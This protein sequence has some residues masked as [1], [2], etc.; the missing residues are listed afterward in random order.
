MFIATVIC[1]ALL[2]LAFLGSGAMK[3]L[4]KPEI[5]EGLGRLGV[6]PP[7][8]RIIG[9]LELAGAA[10]LLVGFAVP[11]LGISAAVG[12]G[13]LM[14]GALGYHLRAGDYR[15]PKLRGPAFMPV[16][17]LLLAAASVV[18]RALTI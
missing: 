4:G 1:S 10:G 5:V 2:A 16:I 15:D 13:L 17:L 12:L 14:I 6:S 3:A 11:W 18:L 8:V 9:L 7:L